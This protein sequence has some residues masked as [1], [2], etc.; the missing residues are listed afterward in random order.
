MKQLLILMTTVFFILSPVHE[1]N[2]QTTTTLNEE[3]FLITGFSSYPNWGKFFIEQ[4]LVGTSASDISLGGLPPSGL[5]LEYMLSNQFGFTLDGIYNSWNASWE[6]NTYQYDLKLS[7]LRFQI[8]FNYHVP[9]HGADN[10][11]LY[12]GFALGSNSTTRSFDTDAPNS[13]VET[14]IQN[15]F[16]NFPISSRFRIG[17]TYFLK[18]NFGLNIELATGGPMIGLGAVIRP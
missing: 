8:G 10:L 9:D 15:P 3:D 16:L 13:M 12:G 5:K 14:F 17:A 18:R 7:R 11:D 4:Y 1:S 6:Q 2:G